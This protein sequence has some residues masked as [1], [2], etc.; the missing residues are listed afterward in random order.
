MIEPHSKVDK[1][2]YVQNQ[3]RLSRLKTLDFANWIANKSNTVLAGHFWT[4][5]SCCKT[6]TPQSVPSRCLSDARAPPSQHGWST[7]SAGEE[8]MLTRG[9]SNHGQG[10]QRPF[11]IA[12]V[13]FSEHPWTCR[14]KWLK[15]LPQFLD[16][17][18][19]TQTIKN[20]FMFFQKFI[21][22]QSKIIQKKYISSQASEMVSPTKE[23]MASKPPGI[24]SISAWI[25]MRSASLVASATRVSRW[26][27]LGVPTRDVRTKTC[28]FPI[29]IWWK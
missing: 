27:I 29:S 13:N 17:Y 28:D 10:R 15:T 12:G 18:R 19:E 25:I 5:N 4:V 6:H 26:A 20:S 22:K 1:L 21:K 23:F 14:C 24:C 16:S 11:R 3:S 7:A 2:A 8:L 9:R